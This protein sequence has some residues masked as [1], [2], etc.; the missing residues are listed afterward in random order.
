M[1]GD[2]DVRLVDKVESLKLNFMLDTGLTTHRSQRK[3]SLKT[4][5]HSFVVLEILKTC[6]PEIHFSGATWLRSL[7]LPETAKELGLVEG[8]HVCPDQTIQLP[9]SPSTWQVAWTSNSKG[10]LIRNH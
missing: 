6:S 3:E 7:L 5:A 4:T 8:R 2:R 10:K 1:L 9:L